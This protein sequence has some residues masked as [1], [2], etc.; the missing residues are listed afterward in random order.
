MNTS[1][2]RESSTRGIRHFLA[3]TEAVWER[4][5]VQE[6][7]LSSAAFDPTI[8]LEFAIARSSSE[9]QISFRTRPM[10]GLVLHTQ[11]LARAAP[12]GT[13]SRVPQHSAGKG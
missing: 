12:Q 9:L 7:K 13:T 6:N 4:G 3:A 1:K 2:S 8:S 11:R 5:V 10:W